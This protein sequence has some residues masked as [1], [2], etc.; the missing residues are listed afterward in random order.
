MH[1]PDAWRLA[2][3]LLLAGATAAQAQGT[4]ERPAMSASA[5]VAAASAVEADPLLGTQEQYK[6]LRFK[7]HDRK[8]D[9]KE[10]NWWLSLVQNL[11]VG[12]RIVVWLAIAA[13]LILALLRL[14]DWLL[15]RQGGAMVPVV[16]PTHIGTLDIRPEHLP[17]DVGGAALALLQQGQARA[18]L[19]LLYRGALSR[20]VH[21]H[22]VPIRAASTE[23]ECV[24]LAAA[25]L[26]PGAH[27]FLAELVTAW[28]SVAYAHREPPAED[29]ARLC[30]GF[31]AALPA[32]AGAS[33]GA[34]A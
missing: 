20:L 24:A 4:A 5:V 18:A 10:A 31:D 29:I 25:R 13:A 26:A 22:G 21:A 23:R 3:A 14:R 16:A 30:R 17:P 2:F 34:A 27:R 7:D 33:A 15:R 1:L 9:P 12:L 11:S 19:S 6:A 32:A 28:Q 8:P